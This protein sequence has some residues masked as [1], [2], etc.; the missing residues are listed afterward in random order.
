MGC[1]YTD[2]T[3]LL[4]KLQATQQSTDAILTDCTNELAA[5]LL[6]KVIKRTPVGVAP[7]L[8][9][10]KTVKVTGRSGKTKTMLSADAAR[11]QQ[12]WSGYKGGTLRRGWTAKPITKSSGAYSVEIINPT[13]YASYVEYG[14]RQTVGRYVPALGRRLK[15]G[16]VQGKFMMRE[17]ENEIRTIAP[18]LLKSRI[19]RK[20]EATLK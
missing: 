7:T 3:Q 5:R 16:W 6:A 11:L 1:N 15:R 18:A 13:E 14:H 17:S 12:Y 8:Q 9:G 10:D 19:T 4:A 2:V 20:L